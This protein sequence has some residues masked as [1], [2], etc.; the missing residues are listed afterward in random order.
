MKLVITAQDKKQNITSILEASVDLS[1]IILSF[2][3][4]RETSEFY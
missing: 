3:P 4:A 1:P 2:F